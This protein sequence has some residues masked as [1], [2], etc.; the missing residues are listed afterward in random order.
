MGELVAALRWSFCGSPGEIERA[1]QV[2]LSADVNGGICG[3]LIR[4]AMD[5][6]VEI[7]VR[8]AALLRVINIVRTEWDVGLADATKKSVIQGFLDLCVG[9]YGQFDRLLERWCDY[10][11]R[12]CFERPE[13]DWIRGCLR[14][15][16]FSGDSEEVRTRSLL[17]S[18]SVAGWFKNHFAKGGAAF[19]D[20]A[21]GYYRA[22]LDYFR[23]T[24]LEAH[25]AM[26]YVTVYKILH[27]KR[28][29]DI[30]E[31]PDVLRLMMERINV[32]ASDSRVL[33]K[34]AL[35]WAYYAARCYCA[36]LE[37]EGLQTLV[38]GTMKLMND[39]EHPS[40]RCL[41]AKTFVCLLRLPIVWESIK[42]SLQTVMSWLV[43]LFVLSHDDLKNSMGDPQQFILDNFDSSLSLYTLK[44]CG[45]YVVENMCLTNDEF[46]RLLL[47]MVLEYST[48][49]DEKVLFAVYHMAS[50]A[51][52]L[53]ED[54]DYRPLLPLTGSESMLIRAAAFNIISHCGAY[55]DEAMRCV[56]EHLCDPAPL[57]R[58][59][60]VSAFSALME[61]CPTVD[62]VRTQCLPNIQEIFRAFL[63]IIAFCFEKT[64]IHAVDAFFKV[65]GEAIMQWAASFLEV[66][67]EKYLELTDSLL[68]NEYPLR[69]SSIIGNVLTRMNTMGQFDAAENAIGKLLSSFPEEPIYQSCVIEIVRTAAASAPTVDPFMWNALR[70][71]RTHVSNTGNICLADEAALVT[72]ILIKQRGLG[73]TEG[74]AKE[75]LEWA[76][77]LTECDL[78]V[79][80]D[81][82]SSVIFACLDNAE[83][84]TGISSSVMPVLAAA[85][86]ENVPEVAALI[87]AIL[88]CRPDLI[89]DSSDILQYFLANAE[90]PYIGTIIP[91]M[92]SRGPELGL[93]ILEALAERI[94]DYDPDN[95]YETETF[96]ELNI[97]DMLHKLTHHLE[98]LRVENP[99]AFTHYSERT[100]PF[101]EETLPRLVQLVD[102]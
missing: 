67:I 80:L 56:L 19:V 9:W 57:V 73:I 21:G 36:C 45:Q 4:V 61:K 23:G 83:L 35:K 10:L 48:C 86:S 77:T 28:S 52:G 84:A 24:G 79:A 50:S 96:K 88:C 11:V 26:I 1:E 54:F 93:T 14:F 101:I 37:C 91:S 58:F 70:H 100:F 30:D 34:A 63:E 3:E 7:E 2:L 82:F 38:C 51:V 59:F 12:V 68:E 64:L 92:F 60:A 85:T 39:Q 76:Q 87:S 102:E 22:V 8:I 6:K 43:G 94:R 41:A 40:V 74:H 71:I 90:L 98:Q 72:A 31:A 27:R 18:K 15:E 29:D 20:F 65:F 49:T 44:G 13:G 62:A 95:T 75:V 25:V 97:P 81:M 69:L 16:V 89:M 66:L 78:G 53:T 17:V 46:T 47:G 33:K 5:D 55:S 42:Q 99:A 32:I